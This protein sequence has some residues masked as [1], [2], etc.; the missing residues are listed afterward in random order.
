MVVPVVFQTL[1]IEFDSFG[2]ARLRDEEAESPYGFVDEP[3]LQR[4]HQRELAVAEHVARPGVRRLRI[5]PVNRTVAPLAIELWI[6]P[7]ER[8]ILDSRVEGVE[9]SPFEMMTGNRR[10]SDAVSI[11]SR[12]RGGVSGAQAL[13]A[14]LALEMAGGIVP[15]PLAIITRNLGACGELIADCARHLF[16]HA[17]PD[18]SA[19]V[20]RATN[21]NLWQRAEAARAANAATHGYATLAALLESLTPPAGT[22]Y[23]EALQLSRR[24]TEIVTLVYGKS[25]NPSTLFPGGN[26][27]EAT[28]ETFN[29]ILGRINALL[30]YAKKVTA[31]WDDLVEFFYDAEPKYRRV[32]EL[33][34]NFLS[35][36]LWD[37]PESYTATYATCNEWGSRR[38]SSPGVI[39]NNEKRTSRLTDLNIGLEEF[40]DRAFYADWPAPRFTGDPLGNAISPW[41]PWNKETLPD[42]AATDTRR[43]SWLTAPRWDREPMETGSLARLWINA[44]YRHSRCEFITP[45][46]NGLDINI[47]KGTLPARQLHWRLPERPNAL[48]RL[49][50]AAYQIGYAGMVAYASLLSAFDCLRRGETAMSNRFLLPDRS[51]GIGFWEGGSGAITHHLVVKNQLITNYQILG[52]AEWMASSR[53]SSAGPGVIENALIN[54]PILE[55]TPDGEDYRGIDILRVVR[56][57]AP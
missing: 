45:V 4:H 25:P 33:A 1:P 53:D 39:V 19:P 32:G 41:H 16:I 31:I 36:G 24:A 28:R 7:G 40:V 42:P 44:V 52:P 49:R 9:F 10:A 14:A 22:L 37:D 38:L 11:T 15:P 43:Y 51:L 23:L 18:Y 3:R 5:E 26:G 12:T 30:D 35:V 46:R 27:I 34:G 56:S 8:R 57:F 29:L 54:T 2:R 55:A 13:A 50:A 47:P 6:E 48:E 17:G 20:V 21:P